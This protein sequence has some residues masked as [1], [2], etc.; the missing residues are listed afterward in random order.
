M[1]I[2]VEPLKKLQVLDVS[3]TKVTEE[4]VAYLKKTFPGCRINF[5]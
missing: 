3:K 5:R 2:L 4:G 1:G